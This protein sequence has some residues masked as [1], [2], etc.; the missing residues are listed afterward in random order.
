MN[1]NKIILI[2]LLLLAIVS[3]GAV[4]AADNATDDAT[5][6]TVQPTSDDMA[7]QDSEL[8]SN[9]ALEDNVEEENVL[10]TADS[11]GEIV[12]GENEEVLND[13]VSFVITNETFNN[14]F[15]SEGRLLDSVPEGATLDFQGSIVASDNIKAIYINKSVNIISSTKDATITLNTVNGELGKENIAGRFMI[16]S[17]SAVII[18]DIVFNR[19]QMLI[20]D[21]SSVVLDNISLISD[22]YRIVEEGSSAQIRKTPFMK[23]SNINGFTLKNSYLYLHNIGSKIID[24]TDTKEVLIDNNTIY[25]YADEP[26]NEQRVNGVI[27]FSNYVDTSVNITNNN[28]D[29]KEYMVAN[30]ILAKNILFENN[31]LTHQDAYN[32]VALNFALGQS[33]QSERIIVRNN[34]LMRMDLNGPTTMYN[35]IVAFTV[36]S[37]NGILM[38]N[39]TIGNALSV[40]ADST[41]YNNTVSGPTTL[42][43]NNIILKDSNVSAVTISKNMKN[44]TVENNNIVGSV[45]ITSTETYVRNN[46]IVGN[47]AIKNPGACE[48]KDNTINGAITISSKASVIQNNIINAQNANYAVTINSNKN[49]INNVISNNRLYSKLYCGDNSVSYNENYIN[50]VEHNTPATQI[51]IPVNLTMDVISY[52]ENTTLVVNMPGYEGNVSI[53]VNGEKHVVELVNGIASYVITKYNLGTNNVEVIYEDDVN[54]I[55][56]INHTAF[57]V[58]KVGVCPIEL[59]YENA[60]EGKIA[61]VNLVLPSD[62]NGTIVFEITNGIYTVDITLNANGTN[63]IITLPGLFEGN[64]TMSATFS[65]VKYVTNSTSATISFVH[66]PVYKLSAK[67]ISMDYYD[68]TKYKVLVTKDGKAVGAGEIVKITFNGKTTSVKTDKNGYATLALNAAPKT[69]TIKA[70]YQGKTISTKV[71]IKN[72]LKA[73]NLAK[74]K[75]TTI[76][77]TA[78]LKNSKGKAIAGKVVKFK[79]KGKTYSVKTNSKGVATVALKNLA[80]GKYY[81]VSSYGACT[82]KKLITIKK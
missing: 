31:T 75:A 59:V 51:D 21:S 17:V 28:I 10:E 34:N 29:V 22:N 18:K 58:N 69:Y 38:Y 3:F 65:S 20:F 56:A 60:T 80:V 79:I 67:A 54:D 24:F 57:T 41:L 78:T 4:S 53:D 61:N 9:L 23:L 49:Y 25:G 30:N 32:A 62:A 7:I 64:Y 26:N 45:S 5:T 27:M 47:I 36:T 76:K 48:I 81:I 13:P 6:L 40:K 14:Y 39:N 16:D 52:D 11:G 33:G 12:S 68:G 43:G 44:I 55:W 8:D 73:N 35:N 70:V 50:T 74:K 46:T 77:Y 63:N 15:D 37:N 82:V 71:V 19:T 66:V 72:V 2:S 1:F 42:D